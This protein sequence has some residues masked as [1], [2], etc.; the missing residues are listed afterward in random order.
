MEEKLDLLQ[1]QINLIKADLNEFKLMMIELHTIQ[2]GKFFNTARKPTRKKL[3]KI[4]FQQLQNNG[5]R[6]MLNKKK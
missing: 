1:G 4:R 3:E 6:I 5:H 2:T